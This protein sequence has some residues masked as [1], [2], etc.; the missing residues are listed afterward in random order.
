[1]S[2][3]RMQRMRRLVGLVTGTV[4]FMNCTGGTEPK[5]IEYVF[6]QTIGVKWTYTRIDSNEVGTFPIRQ[7][8]TWSFRSL[9][10]T[11]MS[12][13]RWIRIDSLTEML[14]KS[15]GA[16][17]YWVG[18]SA[19]GVYFTVRP[20]PAN[21]QM[22]SNRFLF[23]FP[24]ARGQNVAD[25]DGLPIIV[26][27]VDTIIETPAGK[28]RS[29]RYDRPVHEETYFVAPGIGIVRKLY[30]VARSTNN[31]TPPF[32]TRGIV[33]LSAIEGQPR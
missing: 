14:F 1:M 33:T 4:A 5:E 25:T 26:A 9:R 24:V 10:D 21:A 22:D 23:P 18:Q 31:N 19:A 27:A 6:P 16:T 12:G 28:F 11:T 3:W 2:G 7:P 8:E 30:I 29:I 15:K 17:P 20:W 13:M 32:L